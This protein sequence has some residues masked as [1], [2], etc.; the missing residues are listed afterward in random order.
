LAA[1]L[2]ISQAALNS[3]LHKGRRELLACLQEVVAATVD[4]QTQVEEEFLRIRQLLT[5]DLK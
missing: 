5:Q 2:G 3:R 4:D 1:R